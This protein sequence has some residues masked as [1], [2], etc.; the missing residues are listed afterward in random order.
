MSSLITIWSVAPPSRSYSIRTVYI[1]PSAKPFTSRVG[2][3]SLVI[4]SALSD[5][6]SDPSTRLSSA[7]VNGASVS[8]VIEIEDVD[9]S[10]K[11]PARSLI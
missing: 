6:E 8:T 4:L 3:L 1:S 10:D 9:A 2:V 5:P 11:L 7:F